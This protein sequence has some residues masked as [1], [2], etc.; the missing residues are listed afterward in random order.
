MSFK[1]TLLNLVYENSGCEVLDYKDPE[2]KE[3]D[4]GDI[5]T[6]P[7]TKADIVKRKDSKIDEDDSGDDS[8]L[9]PLSKEEFDDIINSLDPDTIALI[10]SILNDNGYIVASKEEILS[11]EDFEDIG[12]LVLEV[13]EEISEYE[14]NNYEQYGATPVDESFD[15]AEVLKEA[16]MI[17]EANDLSDLSEQ[18]VDI[19]HT[20]QLRRD[21]KRSAWKR[22]AVLRAR[23]RKT[24]EG[25]RE[26]KKAL[27]YLKKYRRQHKARMKRYSQKYTQV[28]KGNTKN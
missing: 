27:K 2:I 25:R 9:E 23:F 28:W 11:A 12:Y 14:A 1:D 26:R 19:A 7:T 15:D 8:E 22:S 20:K 21:R 3:T 16:A 17:L 24:G 5:D 18:L 10:I 4:S 13:L 6:T